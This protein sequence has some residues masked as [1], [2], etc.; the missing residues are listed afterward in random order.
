MMIHFDRCIIVTV[1]YTMHM[2]EQYIL[3]PKVVELDINPPR[4]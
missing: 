1:C 4:C 2:Y 3:Q